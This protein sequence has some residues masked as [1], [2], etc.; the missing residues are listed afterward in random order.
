M[1]WLIRSL[2]SWVVTF[3]VVILIASIPFAGFTGPQGVLAMAAALPSAY[4]VGFV[5]WM[6]ALL[7]GNFALRD[8]PPRDRVLVNVASAL[9]T[10]HLNLTVIMFY[11]YIARLEFGGFNLIAAGLIG[12]LAVLGAVLSELLVQTRI[13]ASAPLSARDDLS[14]PAL[15]LLL[16]VL[17]VVVLDTIVSAVQTGPDL[18]YFSG[19]MPMGVTMLPKWFASVAIAHAVFWVVVAVV[20]LRTPALDRRRAMVVLAVGAVTAGLVSL[21]PMVAMGLFVSTAIASATFVAEAIAVSAI[22]L[23]VTRGL[24][25][26]RAISSLT[27]RT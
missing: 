5:G 16:I 24:D 19:G 20:T 14:R 4:P 11:V 26:R 10:S 1:L 23:R 17:G 3:A 21:I 15:E 2:V 22:V 9:L 8:R 7:I 13:A 27:A 12:S 18:F 25:A 6:I